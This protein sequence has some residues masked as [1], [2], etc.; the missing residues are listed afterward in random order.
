MFSKTAVQLNTRQSISDLRK[1]ERHARF[2]KCVTLL[3]SEQN[4]KLIN[5]KSQSCLQ[6]VTYLWHATKEGTHVCQILLYLKSRVYTKK[7]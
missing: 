6:K 4:P 7:H 1:S 5:Q 2:A 3:L